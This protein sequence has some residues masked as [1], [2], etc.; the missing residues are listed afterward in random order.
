MAA[1]AMDTTPISWIKRA[2][3]MGER[4]LL[5]RVG[6]GYWKV[7]VGLWLNY[8]FGIDLTAT[9]AGS[10]A[11]VRTTQMTSRPKNMPNSD[12]ECRP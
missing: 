1:V 8:A 5:V 2:P 6:G 3:G 4:L 10:A 7:L 12:P 11:R 9:L